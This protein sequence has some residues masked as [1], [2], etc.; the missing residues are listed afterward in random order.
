MRRESGSG[1][2]EVR[3]VSQAEDKVEG[4]GKLTSFVIRRMGVGGARHSHFV[5]PMRSCWWRLI[6]LFLFS[7]FL[8]LSCTV[9]DL[10]AAAADRAQTGKLRRGTA[11]VHTS[12]SYSRRAHTGQL[13]E[14]EGKKRGRGR[15][16]ERW[17]EEGERRGRGEGEEEE[18]EKK[19]RRRRG[20]GKRRRGGRR[21]GQEKAGKEE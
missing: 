5:I 17:E 6:L 20:R 15:G 16:G 1:E 18:K 13:G 2:E 11:G 7:S 3:S 21:G 14:G 8:S 10:Q 12:T 4:S 19:R 9:L